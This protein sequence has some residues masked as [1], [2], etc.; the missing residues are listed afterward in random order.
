VVASQSPLTCPLVEYLI[1][2]MESYY[3]FEK[4]QLKPVNGRIALPALPGFGIEID[5]TRVEKETV[6][7]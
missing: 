7:S 2:K 3:F 1:G 6:L 4:H 5:P